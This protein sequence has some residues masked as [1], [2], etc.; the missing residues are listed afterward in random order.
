MRRKLI[1]RSGIA[2]TAALAV[3]G[4]TGVASAAIPSGDGVIHGC[5]NASSNP[6]GVL[7][8][9]DAEAGAKCAKHEKALDFN[10]RGPQGDQG[11]PGPAGPRGEQGPQGEQGLTGA[12]GEPGLKGDKGD[13]GSP[14]ASDA[15]IVRD[16]F[17]GLGHW[18]Q[19]TVG[20]LQLPAGHYALFGKASLYNIDASDPQSAEC[21]LSTGDSTRVRLDSGP[22]SGGDADAN[23]TSVS[24][25]DLLTLNTPGTVTMWCATFRGRAE[26]AKF[27]AIKVG[28]LHG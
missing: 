25:Q 22:G 9:I 14:G 26:M 7:R 28:A 5:Y 6:S 8:V 17:V 16:S 10:Q 11:E 3:V 2:V 4:V 13:P 1:N 21:G 24:V 20:T 18:S 19:T 23:Q 12:Q 27:T 15:Y